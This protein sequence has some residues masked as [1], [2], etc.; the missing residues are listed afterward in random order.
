MMA[1]GMRAQDA[2]F[3]GLIIDIDGRGFGFVQKHGGAHHDFHLAGFQIA[4]DGGF[5][6]QTN[7]A[8]YGQYIFAAQRLRQRK[9]FGG[10]IRSIEYQLYQTFAVAQPYEYQ[11]A[12]IARALYPAGKMHG[13][14]GH[15]A[16]DQ[17]AIMIALV[18]KHF[19]FL[20]LH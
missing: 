18:R 8:G 1:F 10:T 14:T 11:T 6:A 16:G 19:S 13:F 17:A 20:L 2:V 5:I 15:F 3:I 4:V 9:Q 12:Q 7:L